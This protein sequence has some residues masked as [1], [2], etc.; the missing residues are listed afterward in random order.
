M[1]IGV[2]KEIKNNENRVGLT[3]QAV[4]VLVAVGHQVVVETG[5]GSGSGFSDLQYQ[6]AGAESLASGSSVWGIAELVVK[7]KEPVAIE[8]PL[9]RAGQIVFTY[10]HLAA[11]RELTM[12]CL[13]R[14]ITAMA[15]ET[16]LVD[17]G[18]PLLKP[19]SAVAGRMS[20]LVGAYFLARPFGG[21][22]LLP[23]GIDGAPPASVLILGGGVV[24]Q[25]AAQVAIGLGCRVAILEIDPQKL[26]YLKK[27]S[28]KGV[29]LVPSSPDTLK[30][31]LQKADI[32]IGAVLIPGAQAPKLVSFE[33]L[34]LIEPGSVV[35]DVAIDQGGC[36][37]SSRMTTHSQPT[38]VEEGVVHYCVGNMPGA[39]AR[40]A[41]LALGE[42]TLP[43]CL[44]LAKGIK[45]ALAENTALQSGLATYQGHLLARPVAEAFDL[46]SR[47][48]EKP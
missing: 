34:K 30:E 37:A 19:M 35:V 11:N 33:Q 44:T 43:Y 12:A 4:K 15:Y 9:M 5:A 17:G 41:T 24:G 28:P 13:D 42:A 6:E 31:R 1:I 23:T 47:W 3:P 36:F 25:N 32:I 21:S 2:P 22:G 20:V 8:Y 7:V 27:V 38:Y 10:F 18:L 26:S 14:Q 39:Y 48:R 29:E 46:M 16:I 40:T 45:I